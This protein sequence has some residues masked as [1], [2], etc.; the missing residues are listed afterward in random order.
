MN[1]SLASI[2]STEK[3]DLLPQSHFAVIF[4]QPLGKSAI[5]PFK[6]LK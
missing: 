2:E 5:I 4:A 6:W 1:M 3:I